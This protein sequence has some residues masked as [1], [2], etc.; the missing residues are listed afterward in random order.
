M[1]KEKME[2][3][4][5]SVVERLVSAELREVDIGYMVREVVSSF[6]TSEVRKQIS[7]VVSE[8]AES[9]VAAQ[10]SALLDGEVTTDDGWGKRKHYESFDALFKETLHNNLNNSYEVKKTIDKQVSSRVDALIKQDLN[11]VVE[12]IVDELTKSKLV[13]K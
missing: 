11:A 3:D 12:K 9:L 8:Q 6:I 4:F 10:L 7:V 13:K 2:I 1:S 5:E